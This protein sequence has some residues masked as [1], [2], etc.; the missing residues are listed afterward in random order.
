MIAITNAQGIRIGKIGR[1]CVACGG[2]IVLGHRIPPDV[3]DQSL[4]DFGECECGQLYRIMTGWKNG[5]LN[6]R[7]YPISGID[8]IG[9]FDQQVIVWPGT[10]LVLD[11]A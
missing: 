8:V 6:V 7:S 3:L 11:D 5:K 4:E 9:P 10:K 1:T 2:M